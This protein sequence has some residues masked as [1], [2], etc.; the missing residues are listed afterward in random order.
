M[1]NLCS[2]LPQL[3]SKEQT[4]RTINSHVRTLDRLV[5]LGRFPKPLVLPGAGS[6]GRPRLA[7]RGTDVQA[8]IDSLPAAN[9]LADVSASNE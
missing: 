9:A 2:P 5:A 8:W 3:L 4:A 7:W 1:T 6:V